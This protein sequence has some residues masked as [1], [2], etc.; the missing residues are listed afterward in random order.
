MYQEARRH[1]G[2]R[3]D[4]TL[5][6]FIGAAALLSLGAWR[7]H[8]MHDMPVGDVQFGS[9]AL[10]ICLALALEQRN[11]F[12]SSGGAATRDRGVLSAII[13]LLAIVGIPVFATEARDGRIASQTVYFLGMLGFISGIALRASASRSLGFMFDHSLVI[14]DGHSL[15]TQGLYRYIRHPAYLGTLLMVLSSVG[16]WQ[17]WLQL[18]TFAIFLYLALLRIRAE[19]KM[20][21]TAF[22]QIY[23]DY[24]RS[25]WRL[26]PLVY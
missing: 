26:I 23:V 17:T 5:I 15:I 20:L 18:G 6:L 2:Y 3:Y 10:V 14:R 16:L 12:R 9:N 19:E 22:G 7:A 11:L 24:L 8:A 4:I 13:T 1:I 21:I 25:S